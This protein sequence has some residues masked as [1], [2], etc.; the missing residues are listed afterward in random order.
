MHTYRGLLQVQPDKTL[1][2]NCPS[3]C[4]PP[5]PCPQCGQN[6]H[7]RT[8]APLSLQGRSVS[9]SHSQQNEGL[10]DLLGLVAEDWHGPE[11]LAPF[12]ITSEESRV[13]VQVAGRPQSPT[14]CYL[15]SWVS[16]ILHR[17]PWWGWMVSS[18]SQK[19][20]TVL[21]KFKIL[22]KVNFK[23]KLQVNKLVIK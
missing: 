12:K 22:I 17:S 5:G 11:T 3:P 8:T 23:Y 16:F 6:G 10:M 18:T 7:W 2:K 9:Y 1:V 14:W 13:A 20:K 4:P 21:F 19:R 15:T